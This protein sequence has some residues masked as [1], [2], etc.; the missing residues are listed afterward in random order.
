MAG[1]SEKA[2][3]I[4]A[5]LADGQRVEQM[6]ARDLAARE[7]LALAEGIVPKTLEERRKGHARAYEPW[8]AEEEVRLRELV[9]AGRMWGRWRRRW[10]GS[11]ARCGAGWCGWGWGG[12]RREA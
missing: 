10:G 4:L 11:R 7:A 1:L 8:T 9:G 12:V 6:L 3:R 2:Q 5:G